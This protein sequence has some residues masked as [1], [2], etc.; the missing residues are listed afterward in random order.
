MRVRV[1]EHNKVADG[2]TAFLPLA[3]VAGFD[4]PLLTFKRSA[5]DRHTPRIQRI[6]HHIS[7]ASRATAR[8][9]D[10]YCANLLPHPLLHPAPRSSRTVLGSHPRPEETGDTWQR[11]DL[12][13][14]RILKISM[15]AVVYRASLATNID[16]PRR[17]TQ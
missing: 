13:D 16:G 8:L 11:S 3:I 9:L 1:L 17:S 12:Y 2:Y 5:I 7:R 6:S 10:P 4:Y 15:Y 14:L